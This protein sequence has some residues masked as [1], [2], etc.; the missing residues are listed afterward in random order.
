MKIRFRTVD[1]KTV[2]LEGA[3]AAAFLKTK[4]WISA[5]EVGAKQP[6]NNPPGVPQ[7]P[8]M[9]LKMPQKRPAWINDRPYNGFGNGSY[10]NG[11]FGSGRGV[12]RKPRQF[13]V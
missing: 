13:G 12:G 10:R 11:H 7:E 2:V 5:A 9:I 6:I 1:H 4:R 8:R 3:E